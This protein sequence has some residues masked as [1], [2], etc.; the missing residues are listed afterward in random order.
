[1]NAEFIKICKTSD[2]NNRKGKRFSLDEENEIAIFRI[3]ENYYAVDNI[4]PHNHTSQI[5]D[6]Y[7]E[8]LYVACPVHGFRFHLVTGEQPSKLGCRLRIFEM[9]IIDEWIYVMR[10]E[11]KRFDFKY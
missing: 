1:M 10:P 9:K 3:E 4:C 5:Y 6:G 2:I 7:L 8:E 11:E